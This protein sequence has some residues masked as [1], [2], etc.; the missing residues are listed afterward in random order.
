[1]LVG[2]PRAVV[3]RDDKDENT[4]GVVV[5]NA[6]AWLTV[7]CEA[8]V[9]RLAEGARMFI[10]TKVGFVVTFDTVVEMVLEKL[11]ELAL[12]VVPVEVEGA[13]IFVESQMI[14]SGGRPATLALA[15]LRKR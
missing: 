12:A 8:L 6:V 9:A 10:A 15:A 14:S 3:V 2:D 4:R 11:V 1:M 13:A 7:R 5:C